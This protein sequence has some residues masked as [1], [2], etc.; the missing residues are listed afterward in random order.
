MAVTPWPPWGPAG[1]PGMKV[2]GEIP[3]L[4]F[5]KSNVHGMNIWPSDKWLDHKREPP[6][7]VCR[8]VRALRRLLRPR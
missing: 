1:G 2:E 7:P 8:A 3:D 5:H 6:G 4:R